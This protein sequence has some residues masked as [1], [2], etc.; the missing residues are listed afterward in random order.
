MLPI[1]KLQRPTLSA[2]KRHPSPQTAAGKD[3]AGDDNDMF[4]WV[5]RECFVSLAEGAV[6]PELM[7]MPAYATSAYTAGEKWSKAAEPS[8]WL[9]TPILLGARVGALALLEGGT[10][11][12]A[13]VSDGLRGLRGDAASKMKRLLP[14]PGRRG[15][16]LTYQRILSAADVTVS[17]VKKK[18]RTVELTLRVPPDGRSLPFESETDAFVLLVWPMM[19]WPWEQELAIDCALGR[20]IYADLEEREM[21]GAHRIAEIFDE[22]AKKYVAAFDLEGPAATEPLA[23][24]GLTLAAAKAALEAPWPTATL[25][26]VATSPKWIA[27]LNASSYAAVAVH[28]SPMPP[29]CDPKP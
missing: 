6:L 8:Q 22:I 25:R 21:A 14:K 18:G 1:A 9:G 13:V 5:P 27:H 20:A 17:R 29:P 7:L 4:V 16:R 26:I 28:K 23:L 15:S 19:I 10:A 11:T 3:Q 24:D 2:A 12:M